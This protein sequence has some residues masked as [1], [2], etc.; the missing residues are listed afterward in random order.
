MRCYSL[1]GC[2][3]IL[4]TSSTELTATRP[5][6]HCQKGLGLS[7]ISTFPDST[8]TLRIVSFVEKQKFTS[9]PRPRSYITTIGCLMC[10]CQSWTVCHKSVSSLALT[11][12][13]KSVYSL[14]RTVCHNSVYRYMDCTPQFSL[15]T[16]GLY[17]TIQ[18]TVQWS[19]T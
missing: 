7:P 18:F 17:A 13:H 9:D 10:H 1:H 16:Y 14:A 3:H 8:I 5:V 19:D 11:V 12:Y 4:S 6:C 15:Q 2:D